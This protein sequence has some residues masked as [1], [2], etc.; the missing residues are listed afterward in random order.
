VPGGAPL[1]P[2]SRELLRKE[3]GSVRFPE[4]QMAPMPEMTQIDEPGLCPS[5]PAGLET[6]VLAGRRAS[7]HRPA[8]AFRPLGVQSY[9]RLRRRLPR[10]GTVMGRQRSRTGRLCICAICVS[11]A[12]SAF[13]KPHSFEDFP[14]HHCTRLRGDP[15]AMLAWRVRMEVR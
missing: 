6:P 8:V 14:Y 11:S 13:P 5:S 12:L 4:T 7:P 9:S 3:R 1:E 2:P 10:R 15:G